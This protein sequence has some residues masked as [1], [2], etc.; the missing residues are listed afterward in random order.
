MLPADGALH[1][2]NIAGRCVIVVL[3]TEVIDSIVAADVIVGSYRR[4]F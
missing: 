4:T 2:A 1:V 3:L